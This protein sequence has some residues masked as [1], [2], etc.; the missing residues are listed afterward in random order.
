MLD[1]PTR[2]LDSYSAMKIVK[3]LN[4]QARQGKIVIATMHQTSSDMFKSLDKLLFLIDGHCIY[5]GKAGDAASY[6]ANIGYAWPDNYNPPDYF[7][8]VFSIDKGEE[9]IK[10]LSYNYDIEQEAKLMKELNS[11]NVSSVSEKMLK[12]DSKS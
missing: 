7:L 3:I 4:K 1:Q 6:F 9:E 2:G 10:Q 5:H 12:D 8:K 11:L